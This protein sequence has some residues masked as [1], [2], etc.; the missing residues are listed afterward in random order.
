MPCLTQN[1]MSFLEDLS[2]LQEKASSLAA[3]GI[4]GAFLEVQGP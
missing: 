1:P 4:N 2:K 3:K